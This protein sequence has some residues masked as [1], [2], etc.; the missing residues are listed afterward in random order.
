V[1]DEGSETEE[2]VDGGGER[3]TPEVVEEPSQ[4]TDR[5]DRIPT[6]PFH[7][8]RSGRV[9]QPPERL[10]D[11]MALPV[12]SKKEKHGTKTTT[13]ITNDIKEMLSKLQCMVLPR[14][15]QSSYSP[16]AVMESLPNLA[17]L[18]QLLIQVG[19][20]TRVTIPDPVG[21]IE[22][23]VSDRELSDVSWPTLNDSNTGGKSSRVGRA[24]HGRIGY[25]EIR[26]ERSSPIR[27]CRITSGS[28]ERYSIPK[29]TITTKVKD[30]MTTPSS[31]VNRT[32]RGL[33]A[34]AMQASKVSGRCQECGIDLLNEKATQRHVTQH[35]YRTFCEC[36]YNS[37]SRDMVLRH[38]R[39]KREQDSGVGHGG[40][41]GQPSDVYQASFPVW[42]REVGLLDDLC[43]QV[44]GRFP[45][46]QSTPKKVKQVVS[47]KASVSVSWYAG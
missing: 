23:T 30:S 3:P 32:T 34:R 26:M 16:S 19:E 38:Q 21:A 15:I 33:L 8:T 18:E 44:E 24:A 43:Y 10:S 11:F 9:S 25:K 13:Q 22:T 37:R 35:Y 4:V 17:D 45:T 41:A 28:S 27:V 1:R 29:L 36:G 12:E 20:S 7:K 2:V 40:D 47:Q 31:W 5:S 46:R 6:M 42:K 14:E 39:L